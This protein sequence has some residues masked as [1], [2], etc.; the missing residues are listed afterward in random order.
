MD[1]APIKGLSMNKRKVLFVI[2][3]LNIGGVQKSVIP[4]LDAVD[5]EHNEVTLY[6]RKNRLDL[7]PLINSNINDIRINEDKTKYYRKPYSAFLVVLIR[8]LHLL[9]IDV[10]K[11]ESCLKKYITLKQMEYEKKHYFT[12]D[13]FDVAVSVVQ[14]Y[15]AAFVSDYIS[16]KRKIMFYR[17]S[18][19]SEHK[20]HERI[21]N[22]FDYIYCVS[23]GACSV[24]SRFYPQYANRMG[25][26]ETFVPYEEIVSKGDAFEITNNKYI[27]STCGRMT[28]VKGFDIAV[29]A[30]EI[31]DKKGIDYIWYFIGDGIER[32]NIE[33]LIKEKGLQKKIE[34]TGM[35]ENPYPYIK[36]SNIYIQ[37]SREESFGRTIK[38]A[39][40]L[41]SLVVSTETVGAKEQIKNGENGILTTIT[42]EGIA[43]GVE[44]LINDNRLSETIKNNISMIDYSDEFQNYKNELNKVLKN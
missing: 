40:I 27:F 2:H 13:D 15:T 16:A 33:Q 17:D 10:S 6:I 19:D 34:F 20:L 11:A 35:L 23:K 43:E 41:K 4:M 32:H 38:E 26:I 39:L 3:Q 5:Y 24:L 22:N 28:S 44:R 8:I 30:A 37:P 31:L 25:V 9:K 14:G 12:N 21:M 29:A 18:T 42:S 7:L 36:S 1:A